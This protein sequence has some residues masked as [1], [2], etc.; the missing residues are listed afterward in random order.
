MKKEWQLLGKVAFWLSWPLL[1]VYL[2]WG[3]RTRVVIV[4]PDNQIL[5]VKGWLGSGRWILPGGGL[6]KGESARTGAI[7]EV[8]EETGIKLSSKQLVLLKEGVATENGLN[9]R[10]I[11]FS[12]RLA[13]AQ[14]LKKQ[15]LEVSA[16]KWLPLPLQNSTKVSQTTVALIEGWQN[17]SKLID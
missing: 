5:L 6:H 16:A 13:I 4:S 7:R 12:A 15:K 14:P 8:W 17:S 11:A 3:Q 2:R 9:F 10:Y 1:K